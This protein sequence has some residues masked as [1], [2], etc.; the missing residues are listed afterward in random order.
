MHAHGTA[1]V[2][3]STASRRVR[4]RR[5]TCY[6]PNSAFAII[7]G[8]SE[9]NP[10][11]NGLYYKSASFTE[12]DNTFIGKTYNVK[13]ANTTKVRHRRN[14]YEGTAAIGSTG[15]VWFAAGS[16]DIA[17]YDNEYEAPSG[18]PVFTDVGIVVR[19]TPNDQALVVK[20]APTTTVTAPVI[21]AVDAAL[22]NQKSYVVTFTV[23]DVKNI[24]GLE[25]ST[26]KQTLSAWMATVPGATLGWNSS[27]W[28]TAT[29]KL[30]DVVIDG[31]IHDQA[32]LENFYFAQS[33]MVIDHDGLLTCRDF[34]FTG[35]SD[36]VPLHIGAKSIEELAWQ[37]AFFRS[38]LVVDGVIYDPSITGIITDTP[39]GW[40]A[41]LAARMCMGQKSDG[42]FVI[43]A[44]DSPGCSQKAAAQKLL[45]LGCVNA[46]NLDGGGSATLWYNGSV[47]NTPS[48]PGGQRPVPA[49]LYV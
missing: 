18:T 43:L 24:K 37:T 1:P 44:V 41:A 34:K 39:F 8:G 5:N 2:L 12:E 29:G 36:S 21:T 32:G 27:S 13:I 42:T 35:A 25:N 3:R 31:A 7:V 33:A 6:I 11:V 17:S 14:K 4:F 48:D 38:P 16:T 30:P 49:V 10:I 40:E 15:F 45:A 28:D 46:F 23:G 19:T 20:A 26:T 47:I 9:V 22:N